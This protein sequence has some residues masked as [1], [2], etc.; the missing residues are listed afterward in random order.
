MIVVIRQGK[1]DWI[2]ELSSYDHNVYKLPIS[3]DG[4]DYLRDDFDEYS[5]CSDYR[6]GNIV[7]GKFV[8]EQ[9]YYEGCDNPDSEV[10][11]LD[12]ANRFIY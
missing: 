12:G 9:A 4:Y 6:L 11:T 3:I 5:N 2:K 8:A 7:G 10:F 1:C